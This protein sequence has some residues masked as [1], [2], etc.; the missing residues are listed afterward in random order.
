[1]ERWGKRKGKRE[2]GIRSKDKGRDNV[3]MKRQKMSKATR[4]EGKR[5]ESVGKDE[6]R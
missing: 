3:G 5:R 2:G 4:E 6:Q 1:M